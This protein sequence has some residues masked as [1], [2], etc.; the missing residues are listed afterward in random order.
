MGLVD[1]QTNLKSLRYGKDRAGGGSSNQPYIK[2]KLPENEGDLGSTG[3]PDFLLRGGLLTPGRILKDT[4]RLT[5]MFFDFKSPNGLLFTAKQNV[6]S[7]TNVNSD[8][9]YSSFE[10]SER[11]SQPEL[12]GLGRFISQAS[13]FIRNQIPLNQGIYTPLSTIGQTAG[14]ALGIHLNKQGLNPFSPTTQGSENGNTPLGLPT[15]LNTIA[16]NG[17]E[18]PK[19]RITGFLSKIN[20][21]SSAG[22]LLYQYKGGPGANLGIGKTIIRLSKDRTGDNNDKSKD[23]IKFSNTFVLSGNQIS[24]IYS[25]EDFQSSRYNP[26]IL[27][28][29]LETS[30]PDTYIPSSYSFDRQ[31]EK[32]VNLGNPGN[33][34]KNDKVALDKINARSLYKTNSNN[35]IVPE[36]NDFVKFRIGVIDNNNPNSKTNIHF[37]AILD[38]MSDSYSADW[39]SQ[40]FMGRGEKFYRYNGFDRSISLSWTVAAQSKAELIPM[41]KKLNYLASVCAPDYSDNGYM[42]GNLVKL[43]V[44]GYLYEQVGIMESITY[45]VPQESPWEIAITYNGNKDSGDLGVESDTELKELPHIIKVTGFKFTPIHDFV[46]SVQKNKYGENDRGDVTAFGRQR[47]IALSRGDG[48]NSVNNYGPPPPNQKPPAKIIFDQGGGEFTFPEG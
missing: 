11:T 5:Q 26:K 10:I 43:T 18:G 32:R 16:T 1:L 46:P 38:G 3:G 41:Y 39:Q 23:L 15:Y 8:V 22:D 19:S 48:D 17:D 4:S 2:S 35:P 7:L 29:F 47:Y 20:N 27:D 31:I 33:K 34:V 24:N 13:N 14:N 6:L 45:D 44:G 9:G 12:S 21:K 40:K 25:N 42:R 36:T 30:K 37:R 28:N